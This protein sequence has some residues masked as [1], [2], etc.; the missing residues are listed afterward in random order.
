MK[1]YL[2]GKISYHGWRTRICP[3]IRDAVP[4]DEIKTIKPEH[5]CVGPYFISCDHGCCHGDTT[6][7]AGYG[8]G[9]GSDLD[10]WVRNKTRAHNYLGRRGL[11]SSMCLEAIRESDIVFAWIDSD[12]AYGTI[13]EIGYAHALGKEIWIGYSEEFM[14]SFF[15]NVDTY[16]YVVSDGVVKRCPEYTGRRAAEE[17]HNMWFIDQMASKIV[18][19]DDPA[20]VFKVF[21]EGDVPSG[22][23]PE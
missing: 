23:G 17:T 13:A 16:T 3:S 8:C 11:V 19:A 5:A 15:A 20:R 1:F 4:G 18:V 6:H 10:W 2:A 22:Y 7:G 21:C 12:T 9:G 14:N